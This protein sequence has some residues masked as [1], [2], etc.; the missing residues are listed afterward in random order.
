MGAEPVQAA[1]SNMFVSSV[2]PIT[3]PASAQLS[4]AGNL[5]QVLLANKLTGP[6]LK[7]VTLVKVDRLE[8][9][10]TDYPVR[11]SSTLLKDFRFGFS[12]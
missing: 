2:G 4:I 7:P 6:S 3:P 8:F 1:N 9:F 10:L 11:L 5:K 12:I